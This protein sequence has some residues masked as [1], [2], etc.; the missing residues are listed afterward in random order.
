MSK[1]VDDARKHLAELCK[2]PSKFRMSILVDDSDSDQ[3]IRKA[4]DYA[5]TL[6]QE[7]EVY[8]R[9]IELSE[10]EVKK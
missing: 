4:L 5:D 7:N 10:P 6:E 9:E 2:D 1:V 8:L 3:I